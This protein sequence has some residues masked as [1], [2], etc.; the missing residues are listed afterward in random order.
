M[1]SPF[2]SHKHRGWRWGKII[3]FD[4]KNVESKIKPVKI[5]TFRKIDIDG[6]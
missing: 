6:L 2:F 3:T 1:K 4:L 5:I